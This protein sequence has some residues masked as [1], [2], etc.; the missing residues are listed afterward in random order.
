MDYYMI[1]WIVLL[2]SASSFSGFGVNPVQATRCPGCGLDFVSVGRH[3]RFC[4][5]TGAVPA[6]CLPLHDWTPPP[7]PTPLPPP[8]STPP[9]LPPPSGVDVVTCI[10]GKVCKNRRGYASHRRSCVVHKELLRSMGGVV[11]PDPT[12][13]IVA[14]DKPI[15]TGA[16][17]TTSVET[18]MNSSAVASTPHTVIKTTMGVSV[19][20]DPSSN[21]PSSLA[22]CISMSVHQLPDNLWANAAPEYGSHAAAMDSKLPMVISLQETV[23]VT[24]GSLAAVDSKLP[25]VISSQATVAHG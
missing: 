20:P 7:P 13:L 25:V 19:P 23:T 8:L 11:P 10:C 6:N 3:A 24:H 21:S 5:G 4:K 12:P 22:S 14:V 9:P 15:P 16:P 1:L 18:N 17:T 2:V